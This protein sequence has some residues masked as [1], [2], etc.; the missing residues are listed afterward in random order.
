MVVIRGK[1]VVVR[2]I[3]AGDDEFI[4]V[5]DRFST[6]LSLLRGVRDLCARS[7]FDLA[8]CAEL[9]EAVCRHKGWLIDDA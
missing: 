2:P 7:W 6:P 3:G 5:M 8:T 4:M 1:V 9:I